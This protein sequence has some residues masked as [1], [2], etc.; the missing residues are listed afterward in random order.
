MFKTKKKFLKTKKYLQREHV[1]R[2]TSTLLDSIWPTPTSY[3]APQSSPA[4]DGWQRMIQRVYSH[5]Y[6]Y[7]YY[8]CC[9]VCDW[10]LVICRLTMTTMV[11]CWPRQSDATSMCCAMNCFHSLNYYKSKKQKINTQ[12]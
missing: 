4:L 6:Y 8:C 3:H 11:W 2:S 9:C 5:Y 7:Y 12:K 1:R 10:W